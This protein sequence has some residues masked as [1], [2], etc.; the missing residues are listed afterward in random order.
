[1]GVDPPVQ[2][3][4]PKPMPRRSSSRVLTVLPVLLQLPRGRVEAVVLPKPV[5]PSPAQP[6]H[7]LATDLP[8]LTPTLPEVVGLPPARHPRQ[9]EQPKPLQRRSS[10]LVLTLL[11]LVALLQL[12]HTRVVIQ[13]PLPKVQ[14]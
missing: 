10:S 1:M 13:V 12:P 7:R 4:E 8:S 9:P 14:L 11:P 3:V 5:V 2:P 6:Q